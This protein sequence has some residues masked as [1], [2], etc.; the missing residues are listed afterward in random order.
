VINSCASL[1]KSTSAAKERI[2]PLG[3]DHSCFQWVSLTAMR[4]KTRPRPCLA[5]YH[6]G[7]VSFSSKKEHFTMEAQRHKASEKLPRGRAS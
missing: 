3:G 7:S 5:G 1:T 2:S 6:A 4:T